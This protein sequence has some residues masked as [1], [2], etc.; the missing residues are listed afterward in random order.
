MFFGGLSP[1]PACLS[2]DPRL[3][4]YCLT[5]PCLEQKHLCCVCHAAYAAAHRLFRDCRLDLRHRCIHDHAGYRGS[6]A[7][8]AII[9][10]H[11]GPSFQPLTGGVLADRSAWRWGS[12]GSQIMLGDPF[13]LVLFLFPLLEQ[14]E[15][16]STRGR[17]QAQGVSR[18]P[19]FFVHGSSKVEWVSP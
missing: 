3:A 2:A 17:F 6:K 15:T 5:Q 12:F 4:R 19:L 16:L 13:L 10:T 9:A 1:A 7:R 14:A 8:A 18:A 11:L